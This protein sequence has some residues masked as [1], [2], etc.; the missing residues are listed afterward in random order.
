M[1]PGGPVGAG[2]ALPTPPS[3]GRPATLALQLAL[4]MHQLFAELK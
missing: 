3:P 2:G 4:I 1:G